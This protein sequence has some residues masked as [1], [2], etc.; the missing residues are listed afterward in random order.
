MGKYARDREAL[1]SLV[2][3]PKSIATFT[4]TT[5]C[6]RSRCGISS[7]TR[8]STSGTRARSR[9]PGDFVTT[10]IGTRAVIM[11][12][13]EDGAIHVLHNRCP[14]KG[15]RLVTERA[16]NTGR[17]IRCPYHAWTFRTDGCVYAIPL[18]RGYEGTGLED[19]AAAK[20]IARVRAV[21]NYRGFVFARASETGIGFD[22]YFGES[23]SSLDNMVDRSPAGGSRWRGRPFATSTGATGRCWS[24]TQTDAC[25]PM[26]AHESSAGTAVRL[27]EEMQQPEGTKKPM[28]MEVIAPFVS[29][30]EFFEEMGIRVWPNGHGH[31][32]VHHSIHSDYSAIPGYFERMAQAWGEERARGILGENRHNTIYFP[33]IMVKA[34]SSSFAGSAPRGRPHPRRELRVPARGRSRPAARAHRHVQPP[35]QRPDLHRR[36]RRP[37]DLRAHAVRASLGRESSG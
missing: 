27:W 17:H 21:R 31:T 19:R 16:G 23:L 10:E 4:S 8:G 2:G 14:H 3:R 7:R 1:A 15:T 24:R 18:R 28:A 5:R 30:Y 22:E 29:R 37:R 12:R 11:V 35:H 33:N 9:R 32:G 25:H 34:R 20:G 36:A 6:S 13:G 26:V